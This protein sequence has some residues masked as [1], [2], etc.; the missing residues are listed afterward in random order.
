MPVI[1]DLGMPAPSRSEAGLGGSLSARHG[2]NFHKLLRLHLYQH[3]M[4]WS[5]RGGH[6]YDR[7]Q[8]LAD[9]RFIFLAFPR[10][11]ALIH[12]MLDDKTVHHPSSG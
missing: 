6:F 3:A 9:V 7:N 12:I 8:H 5:S 2:K 4:W 11:T 1:L 10:P